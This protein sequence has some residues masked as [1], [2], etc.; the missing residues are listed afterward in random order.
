MDFWVRDW[1]RSGFEKLEN[2]IPVVTFLLLPPSPQDEKLTTDRA[3]A[4]VAAVPREREPLL[5]PR[6]AAQET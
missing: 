2:E 5:G 1:V 4:V 3:L 6:A